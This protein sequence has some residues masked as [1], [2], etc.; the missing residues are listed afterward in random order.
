MK[1]NKYINKLILLNK[2]IFFL[3]NF[4]FVLNLKFYGV[5]HKKSI[6]PVR[7]SQRRCSMEIGV[8]KNFAK[9][10]GKHLR[11]SV[12]LNKVTGHFLK[13]SLAQVLSHEF[14]E[15]FKNTYFTE[16]LRMTAPK[17]MQQK[18][19]NSQTH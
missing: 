14:S 8:I 15:I 11:Q 17:A 16:H 1:I 6:Q 5:M 19:F 10:T 12:F 18:P 9:F 7:T 2:I 13:K 4:S 3:K